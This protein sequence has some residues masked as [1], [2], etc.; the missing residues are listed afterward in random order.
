MVHPAH[1]CRVSQWQAA[2]RHHLH[3]VAVTEFET[4]IPSHA[5]GRLHPVKVAAF[6]QLIQTQELGHVL[7]TTHRNGPN[8]AGWT[9]C[10]A[11]LGML[12]STPVSSHASLIAVEVA[13]GQQDSDP[14]A[15]RRLLRVKSM[16]KSCVGRGLHW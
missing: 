14:L 13:A 10:R 4:Q 6:E 15:A 3:Q 5:Q 16:G 11:V 2:F 1:D 9:V 12:G 7:P 8:M